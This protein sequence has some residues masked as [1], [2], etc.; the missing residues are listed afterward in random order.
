MN[1]LNRMCLPGYRYETIRRW[2]GKVRI[3][4]C[5]SMRLIFGPAIRDAIRKGYR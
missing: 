3:Y 4:N 2:G 1:R 5:L